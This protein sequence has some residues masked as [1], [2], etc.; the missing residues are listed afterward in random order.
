MENKYDSIE[1]IIDELKKGRCVIM[2]DAESRENEGDYICAAEFAT[3]ENLNRMASEAKGVI[4]MP[5][6]G[7]EADRLCLAPMIRHNTD[8]HQTAFLESIDFEDTTTGV[9]AFERSM[10]ALA[11]VRRIFALTSSEN[12]G[13]CSRSGQKNGVFSSAR[14]TRKLLWICAAWLDFVPWGFVVKS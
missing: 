7:E 8:N 1:E 5:M 6:S 10:T 14:D 11:A 13:I 12:R 2:Q 3:P 9:S 4:C